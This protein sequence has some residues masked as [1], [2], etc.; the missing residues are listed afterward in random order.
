[1]LYT[2]P[3]TPPEISGA[4]QEEE[5]PRCMYIADCD[6]GSQPRKAVSHIFG[7]NKMCTRL[8]PKMVW[9]Y[10]CR[11]HYQRTRYRNAK[12][13]VKLQYDLVAQQI[14]RLQDWS[15]ENIRTGQGGVV[16]DWSIAVR[17]RE[18]KRLDDQKAKGG[19]DNEDSGD[20][21]P[22]GSGSAAT[23][24]A[25]PQWLLDQ[26]GRGYSTTKLMEIVN[27]LGDELLNGT[28]SVFPD[29]EILPNIIV[30]QEDSEEP[31]GYTKRKATSSHQRSQSMGGA[32]RSDSYP[33]SRSMSSQPSLAWPSNT[34]YNQTPL[35]QKKRKRFDDQ[36]EDYGSPTSQTQRMRVAEYPMD[37]G[38]RGPFGHRP[39]FPNISEHQGYEGEYG[40]PAIHD[41]YYHQSNTPLPAP[42][43]QRYPSQSMA[44]QLESYGQP[45]GELRRPMHKRSQSDMGAIYNGQPAYRFPPRHDEEHLAPPQQQ[46]YDEPAPR[47]YYSPPGF[48]TNPH[49]HPHAHLH[50]H[51]MAPQQGIPH[52]HLRHQSTP[53]LVRS[54]AS[55]EAS[56]RFANHRQTALPPPGHLVIDSP[57][58][59]MLYSERR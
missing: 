14:K 44:S 6:T 3:N 57:Q 7:R 43:P 26:C 51:A 21:E 16:K 37:A 50:S 8:I 9:V 2:A 41:G 18:Q 32:L 39:T 38:R 30:D 11:K 25:V 22:R 55:H 42:T 46:Y 19:F 5:V 34:T 59:K 47:R 35:L 52:G 54:Y 23:A 17:K 12:E 33:R 36:E 27:R 58:G 15:Q 20:E 29:I 4:V 40:H 28:V 56:P 31:K 1:M 48:Y 45:R 53:L 10:Y 13:Y 49:Q 24:T